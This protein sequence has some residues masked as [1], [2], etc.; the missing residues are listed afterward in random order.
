M[1]NSEIKC[2]VLVLTTKGTWKKSAGHYVPFRMPGAEVTKAFPARPEEPAREQCCW[3]WTKTMLHWWS[4]RAGAPA[5]A[6][7]GQ[8][9]L[10]SSVQLGCSAWINRS[11]P[12]SP[13]FGP[14][15]SASGRLGPKGMR[16]PNRSLSIQLTADS[17]H[18]RAKVVW[19]RLNSFWC[20]QKYLKPRH[21]PRVT[22]WWATRWFAGNDAEP[23][24]N[25]EHA[26]EPR[27]A[28][29]SKPSVALGYRPREDTGAIGNGKDLKPQGRSA[30]P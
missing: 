16:Q 22:Q 7:W 3:G 25:T 26:G 5:Q 4:R 30:A 23:A 29:F 11:H 18:L 27:T 1:R 28:L 20:T 14:S 24:Q 17:C 12:V 19:H 2:S 15:C 13:E 21:E 10:C 8:T 6:G 9:V